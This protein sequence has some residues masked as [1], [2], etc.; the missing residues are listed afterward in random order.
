MAPALEVK[1]YPAG[2]TADVQDGAAGS[3]NRFPLVDRASVVFL[4]IWQ[5]TADVDQTIFP[6]D[7]F[8]CADAFMAVPDLPPI[9][10]PVGLTGARFS[11]THCDYC[12]TS[13]AEDRH[14]GEG[15]IP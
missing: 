4:K 8:I 11:C 9:C 10:V 13:E 6:F 15:A 2:A 7:D 5:G 14:V 1:S 12:F 3:L